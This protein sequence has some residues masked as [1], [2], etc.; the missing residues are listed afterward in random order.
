MHAEEA[1]LA[2][3]EA[4]LGEREAATER[5]EQTRQGLLE[6]AETR[7]KSCAEMEANA[8]KLGT[9]FARNYQTRVA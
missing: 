6:E 1:K 9:P 5:V 2:S 7:L 3:Q 8:A 4:A